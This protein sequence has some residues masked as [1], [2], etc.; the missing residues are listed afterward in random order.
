[1]T[2]CC[3]PTLCEARDTIKS[4]MRETGQSE[5]RYL[6]PFLIGYYGAI[7]PTVWSAVESMVKD[8]Y[9]DW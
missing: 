8:C 7:T 1:M 6:M 9:L 3:T 5:V 4:W 2:R